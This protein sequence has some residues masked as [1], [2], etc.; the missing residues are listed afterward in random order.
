MPEILVAPSRQ[1]SAR[2]ARTSRQSDDYTGRRA[3]TTPRTESDRLDRR[4]PRRQHRVDPPL[5][6]A[7]RRTGRPPGG[8]PRDGADRIPRRGPGPA[9]VL[10]RGVAG[11][12]ACARRAPG[13]GGLRGTPGRRRLPRPI[14]VRRAALRPARRIAAER[15]R[16]AA[17]RTDRAELRQAPPAQ[18]RRLRRVPVLRAGRLDACRTGAR[19][20]CGA[21]DLRGPLAG[22]RPGRRPR[23]PPGPGCCCRSTPRRTSG[24][25]T[26]PGWNWSASGPRRPAARPRTS[27]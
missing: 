16:G 12:A 26:T 25:R 9:V 19:H 14:R 8:V 1:L 10:R 4:R 22:R 20:R 2:P 11:G 21:R 5:D 17:P 6:P 7:L 15:R 13:R 24:T 3:S 23:V 27:R 18:L